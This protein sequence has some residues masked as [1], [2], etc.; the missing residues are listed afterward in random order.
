MT[1]ATQEP[2]PEPPRDNS[3]GS[4]A[5]EVP[6]DRAY[7]AAHNQ[8]HADAIL[9]D[10]P[11]ESAMSVLKRGLAITPQLRKGLGFSVLMAMMSAVGKLTIPLLV[12]LAVDRGL[13]GGEGVRLGYIFVACLGTVGLIFLVFLVSRWAFLRL[14]D[15]T[16][17]T[18]VDLRV[19]GFEHVHKLSIAEHNEARLGVTVARVTSDV[20]QLAKFFEW[21][22]MSW[23]VNG[24]LLIGT[25]VVMFATSWQLTLV[26]LAAYLPLVPMLRWI[27]KRQLVAYS[28]LRTR[29]GET[30]GE[31]SEGIGGAQAIRAYGLE[32]RT[33][34]RL[35]HAIDLQYQARM[36]AVRFFAVLFTLGDFFGAVALAAV[37]GVSVAQQDAWG[38]GLGQVLAFL[39]LVTI[40]SGP[41][42]ELSEILD[43]T[44]IA[45]AGWEKILQLLDTPIE[46][47]EPTDGATIASGPIRVEA[48]GVGFAYRDGAPVLRDVSVD[49]APGT[50]VAIVGETGSGKTTFAKLLVRL[51]D[52]TSGI[53]ALNNVDLAAVSPEARRGAVRM[54]P[55]DGFLFDTTIVEN[56][57]HGRPEASRAEI[58]G[59]FEELGLLEW[60]RSLPQGLDTPVGER[61]NSLS[62]GER[63][64]IALAR[65]QLADP[66]LLI[67]DE[68]TSAVDPQTEQALAGA[69]QHLAQG[70]TTISIAHRLSTAEAADLVL[71]F[72]AGELVQRGSHEELVQIPG[73]Y[74]NLYASWI[75]NTRTASG[76]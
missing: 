19:A 76:T 66:G 53:I 10:R 48:R 49:I 23:I 17:D 75:G 14:I 41:V 68:A 5:T 67:L 65:A 36:K 63:Q 61:G 40:L 60:V 39:F 59:A 62:V 57:S 71:V 37:I 31:F 24:T 64:L 34:G 73:F 3:S 28:E 32:G 25:V 22:G 11:S 35:R 74:A 21:S 56:V 12:R 72:D 46:I 29:V 69:L 33:R 44:Q 51:A 43:Q 18:L 1:T 13:T 15:M 9:R 4:A 47:V 16:E 55:Q 42:G 26:A 8:A 58:E 6:N 70:R 54:V 27:Q 52:P 45:L 30:L 2:T 7:D 50:S 20:E 38:L